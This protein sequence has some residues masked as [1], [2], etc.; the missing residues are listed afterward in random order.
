[1]L[2]SLLAPPLLRPPVARLALHAACRHSGEAA[3]LE[4]ADIPDAFKP[5]PKPRPPPEVSLLDREGDEVRFVLEPQG[6]GLYVGGELFCPAIEEMT[7]DK[8][9]GRISIEDEE[10]EGSFQLRE[11]EQR[12]KATTLSVFSQQAGVTWLGDEPLELPDEVEGV[13]T[14]EELRESRPGVKLLWAQ[15]LEVYPSEAD[16]KEAVRR[17]SAIVLPYLNRPYHIEGSWRVLNEIMSE[18]EALEVITKNPGI[19]ACNPSGLKTS[20]KAAVQTMAGVVDVVDGLWPEGLKWPW[21]AP[22]EMKKS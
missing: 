9:D 8:A 11:E 15:L 20:S 21:G 22:E 3:M 12:I 14:N 5:K 13:L 16:A 19:L 1:V 17:N 4:E 10:V 6:L 2:L 7:Y 18:A